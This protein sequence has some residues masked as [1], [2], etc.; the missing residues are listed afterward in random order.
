MCFIAPSRPAK[1]A[2]ATAEA[3]RR[4]IHRAVLSSRLVRNTMNSIRTFNRLAQGEKRLFQAL[5]DRTVRL[6]KNE[7]LVLVEKFLP[8]SV[9]EMQKMPQESDAIE[10]RDFDT[11]RFV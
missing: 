3:L 7:G 6:E 4:R 2:S 10:N 8:Q 11:A 1:A 9:K 5:A